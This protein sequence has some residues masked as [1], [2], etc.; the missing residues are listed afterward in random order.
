VSPAP[1]SLAYQK[2]K[3][4][5]QAAFVAEQYD[6]LHVGLARIDK[7]QKYLNYGFATGSDETYESRQAELCRR[8]FA[9][10]DI[11]PG[12]TVVDV[13]FGSGEQDLLLAREHEF[14]VL[15]G[16]NVSALQVEFARER[17]REAGMADRL[18]FHH[19]AAE[20]LSRLASGSVEKVIAVECAFYFDRPRFYAEAARVLRPGGR[21]ALADIS[22]GD[23]G[24]FLV[25]RFESLRRVGTFAA[26]RALWERHFETAQVVDIAANVRPGAQQTVWRCLSSLGYG[27]ARN[28]LLTWLSLGAYTQGV[29]AGL[30]TGLLRYDLILLHSRADRPPIV[31][32][33]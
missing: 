3:G 2:L 25:D 24:A 4:D 31:P 10:A 22:F 6:T 23:R 1:S 14:A 21:L 8:V 33:R 15:H 5:E 19:G 16:F 26:N 30:A 13:G 7:P 12:E 32:P 11:G 27:L 20:D 17:A 28:E 29:V 18:F 9:L